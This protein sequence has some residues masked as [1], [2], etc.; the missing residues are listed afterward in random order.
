MRFNT[1]DRLARLRED[2]YAEVNPI[3][4]IKTEL[5]S[6]SLRR[7]LVSPNGELKGEVVP[8]PQIQKQLNECDRLI[9]ETQQHYEVKARQEANNG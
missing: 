1:F 5:L 6:I 9:E 7:I 2:F 3:V 8:S 4:K